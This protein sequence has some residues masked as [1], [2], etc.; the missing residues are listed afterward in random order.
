MCVTA[1]LV[2]LPIGRGSKVQPPRPV[3]VSAE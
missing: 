2:V 1:T 3:L